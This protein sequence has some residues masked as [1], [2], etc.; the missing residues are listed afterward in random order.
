MKKR[1]IGR[2]SLPLFL[3]AV[4]MLLCLVPLAACGGHDVESGAGQ[5]D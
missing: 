1:R 5:S 3:C 4:M 2:S